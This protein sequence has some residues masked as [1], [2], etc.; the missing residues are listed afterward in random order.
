[1]Y[2]DDEL[3][4]LSGIQH[5]AFCERQF[6]LAYV[7]NMWK[8]NVLTMQGHRLHERADNP[9]ES[10]FREGIIT[11]RGI[12]IISYEL[13]LYG[14]ADVIEL[15][16]VES[17][18]NT[19]RLK[20]RDGSWSIR[21]VEYKRGK[22]KPDVCDEVQLCA[23]AICLEEMYQVKIQTADIFYG[24]PRRRLQVELD[25]NLRKLTFQYSKR[26]H[27][28]FLN[29]IPPKPIYKK[30]CHSCSLFE[31][32]KPKQFSTTTSVLDYINKMLNFEE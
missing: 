5:I 19:I 13:G 32:C 9:F 30:H 23:Q 4:Q 26:M 3:L 25:N 29:D 31:I 15:I 8:E 21:P 12:N 17:A 24:E 22:P 11:L 10:D 14:K 6:F 2:T 27:Q 1:M 18:D 16:K 20:N 28:L 7:E